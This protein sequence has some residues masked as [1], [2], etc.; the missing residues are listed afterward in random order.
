MERLLKSADETS[1][2]LC[3]IVIIPRWSERESWNTLNQSK[4]CIKTVHLSQSD[5]GFCEGAQHLRDHTRRYR[6]SNHDTSIF[7]LQSK[8]G[9]EKWIVNDSKL[10][11]LCAAFRPMNAQSHLVVEKKKRKREEDTTVSNVVVSS[12][13]LVGLVKKKK[14]SNIS[15]GGEKKKKHKKKKKRCR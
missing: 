4:W 14:N 6:Q 15:P 8:R 2:P 5:H 1:N 13:S 12:S 11:R 9:A 7:F 3:F 10:D